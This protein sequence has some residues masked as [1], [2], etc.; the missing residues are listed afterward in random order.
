MVK[1]RGRETDR[2]PLDFGKVSHFVFQLI[3]FPDV[4]ALHRV[5]QCLPSGLSAKDKDHLKMTTI[6]LQKDW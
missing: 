3:S 6:I 2:N 5:F 4:F 1:A